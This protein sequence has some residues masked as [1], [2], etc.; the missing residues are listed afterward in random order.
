MEISILQQQERLLSTLFFAV[1]G[2]FSRTPVLRFPWGSVM[3]S[4]WRRLPR[5]GGCLTCLK[6]GRITVCEGSAGPV[7]YFFSKSVNYRYSMRII[8]VSN[9]IVP[10][11][12]STPKPS[13]CWI[14]D[15]PPASKVKKKKKKNRSC[16]GHMQHHVL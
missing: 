13:H 3:Y 1:Y 14:S 5:G 2:A 8:F 16:L 9:I 4:A 7:G 11:T 15:F 6:Q 10:I 12:F